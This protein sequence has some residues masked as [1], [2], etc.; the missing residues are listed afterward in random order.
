[1]NMKLVNKCIL[2]IAILTCLIHTNEANTVVGTGSL[3]APFV[4]IPMPQNVTLLKEPGIPY[5]ALKSL[6]I[7]GAFRR[8]VLSTYLSKLTQ[9]DKPGKGILTIRLDKSAAAPS[10]EEGYILTISG[11]GA[12]IISRGEAG[13][14]YGCQ[15]LEQLIEDACQFGQSIP[16]CK[17][18]D[19]PA[20]PYRAV[21]IDVKHHLDHMNYYYESIDRLARYKINAVIFEFEDKLRYRRQPL[22]GAPQ[23]I[24][25]DEMAALTRYAR[26]RHIEI[27]PLIQGLGHATFILKHQQYAHLREIEWNRWA[28]CPFHEG[29]YQVLF[30]L[31]RDAIDAT[32]GSRYLHIG[33]DEIG[34][35]GVCPR[36]KPAAD[37]D[38]L[39]S[40]NLYW[41]KRVCEFAE[42]N[43][44]IPIFWDD[45]PLKYA[46]VYETTHTNNF[47]EDEAEKLWKEGRGKLDKLLEDFPKNCVYM[48]WEYSMARQPGNIKA[49]EWYKSRGLKVMGATAAQT[50]RTTL[51]PFDERDK[52]M[53]TLGLP[54]IQ[55]FMQLA[56]EKKIDGMLTTSWDDTSPLMET[57]WRGYIASAEYGWSPNGRSLN[58]FDNAWLQKEFGTTYPNFYS[59]YNQL[60]DM[61]WFRQK[62]FFR[63]GTSQDRGNF[64]QPMTELGHWLPPTA[65]EE[66]KQ[67]DYK[68]LL[69]DLPDKNSPGKWSKQY[70]DL[71]KEAESYA[72]RY[73]ALK[74]DISKLYRTSLRNRYHWEVYDA[75]NDFLVAAPHLL[76]ALKQSDTP[77][78]AIREKGIES[79]RMSLDE[80]SAAWN[81]LVAVYGKIRFTSNP[82]DYV[83]DRYFH[84]SSQKEDLTWL[85]QPEELYHNM[86]RKWMAD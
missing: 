58:E 65:G 47:N 4:V 34:N 6:H 60:F 17:I 32:P 80:F 20:I 19:S 11:G 68:G 63:K 55:S 66:K 79:V 3:P 44:R 26:E 50:Y 46:G 29:T 57:V 76:I 18:T 27:S 40:L 72:G 2:S 13:L 37:K 7:S 82:P 16:A 53:A 43:G 36:C 9:S 30:D 71:L 25:I 59:L 1:M 61:N 38:G 10:S 86:I 22:V 15:T 52:G 39:L 51:V 85:I 69:I 78:K 41:L 14:F 70:A 75:L 48:R 73:P 45:M 49:L 54:A 81:N 8:P 5:N 84:Y 21:H 33:G 83:S 77:D 12:E 64:L 28:F 62:S 24:S 74:A 67:I 31:Y 56:S 23:A 35:I 42:E